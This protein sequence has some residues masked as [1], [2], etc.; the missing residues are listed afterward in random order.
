MIKKITAK[1]SGTILLVDDMQANLEVMQLLLELMSCTVVTAQSGKEAL[2]KAQQET[3]DVI[4][5]DIQMPEM[6]GIEA[7]ALLRQHSAAP[8][9]A[10]TAH[11]ITG[12]KE[13]YLAL[14]F[15]GY[16]AKPI[17]GE[18]VENILRKFLS[19]ESSNH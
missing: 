12:D 11:A 3:F 4:F 19:I 2:E 17:T 5:M 14:G 18:S 15:E 6:D 7:A 13:K 9:I 16:L 10:L 8:I 1:F